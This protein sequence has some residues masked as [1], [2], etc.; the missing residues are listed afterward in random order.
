MSYLWDR[1]PSGDPDDDRSLAALEAQLGRYRRSP[2]SPPL[3]RRRLLRIA[4]PFALAAAILLA[5]FL[6]RRPQP[7]S[8]SRP[9]EALILR[10]TYQA[11]SEET[12]QVGSLGRLRF[13]PGAR[14]RVIESGPREVLEL[15]E[16]SFDALIIANPYAFRVVTSSARLDDLG[17]AYQVSLDSSGSGRIAVSLGWVHAHGAGEDSFVAQGYESTFSSGQPPS[18]PRKV[19]D[20]APADPLPLLH[21]LWREKRPEDRLAAFDELSRLFP[22]PAS[23][24]RARV[25]RGERGV[26][27]DYWP[28]LPL[29]KEI[30]F[31]PGF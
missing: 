22:P 29:G 6:V 31:P 10:K 21:R 12:V 3:P 20:P 15:L 5:F 4:L 8:W 11:R 26:V 19:Q 30:P 14:Y 27:R 7:T 24:T 9:G 16:G 13:A 18:P 28:A 1:T 23:V 2:A 17:C 25:Q